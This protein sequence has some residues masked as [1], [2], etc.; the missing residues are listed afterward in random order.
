MINTAF[1]YWGKGAQHSGGKQKKF[2]YLHVDTGA[3]A[4]QLGK[5]IH[6]GKLKPVEEEIDLLEAKTKHMLE[7]L[8]GM[9]QAEEKMRDINGKI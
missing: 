3:D 5:E 7:E 2:I 4:E 9:R 8:D 6:Q 1:C